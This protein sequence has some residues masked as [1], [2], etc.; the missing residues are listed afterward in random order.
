[1]RFSYRP[2]ERPIRWRGLDVFFSI[3]PYCPSY[4][5]LVLPEIS[6]D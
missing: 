5:Y 2:E 4:G 1:M 3:G 6:E